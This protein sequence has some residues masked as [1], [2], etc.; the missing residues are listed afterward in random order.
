M[1]AAMA[2]G[3]VETEIKLK[4]ESAEHARQLLAGAGFQVSRERVF[5]VNLVYD[6]AAAGLRE[7]G[8]VLRVRDSGGSGLLTFKGPAARGRHK[9]REEVEVEV[10]SA[11]AAGRVLECLGYSP[12]FR[13]EK[14]RTEFRRDEG[15]VATVDETPAGCYFEL[16]GSAE[17]IDAVAAEL[18]YE[19]ADYITTSYGTLH[20]EYCSRHGLPPCDMVFRSGS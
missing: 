20:A 14:F 17:W 7:R 10:G 2:T 12:R 1:R 3:P 9:S 11:A 6:S 13:Y 18:G 15:G 4:A 19:E 8:A 16:E 5:E